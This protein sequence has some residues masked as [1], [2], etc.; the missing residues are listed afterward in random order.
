MKISKFMKGTVA[1][2][3]A[4]VA[5]AACSGE[6][7]E[8][9]VKVGVL[10]A[11]VSGEEALGFKSYLQNYV[12]KQ[13]NYEFIYSPQIE[14]AEQAKS[15]A[16]TFIGQNCKA[17]ID[18][19]DKNRGDLAKLCNDNQ[20]YFAIGSGM[21]SDEDFAASKSLE[22]FVG[23]IGPNMTTEYETGLAMGQYYKDA[24]NVTKIG[25]YGAFIPNPMHLYRMAGLLT[26]LGDTY[27][28]ATGQNIVFTVFGDG[29]QF[30]ASNIAGDVAIDYCAGFDNE[31]AIFATVGQ[32]IAK[33]PDAFLSVGMTTTFFADTLDGAGVE[34]SDI[35]SFTSANGNHMK[36][37]SLGYLAGKYSSSLGPVFAAIKSAIDGKAIRTEAGEAFSLSQ[38][39]WTAKSSEEF[40]KFQSA[41][42]VEN[43][44]FNKTL[45][46]SLIGLSYTE[47]VNEVAK[48]RTPQ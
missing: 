32:I 18:M 26:G 38:G 9:V 34:Y 14:S 35:D 45:L 27:K 28:G 3:L 17:I 41:D 24:K 19:A 1:L 44:I 10:V 7:T 6:S 39:Y 29:A 23:Q 48:D 8:K 40:E 42:S 15:Q 12:A 20:V 16:E 22:Y 2:A 31:G 46:D 36:N 47:F 11:D 25:V 21:M 30:D 13:Y 33:N 5:L 4:G 37:G 43:P